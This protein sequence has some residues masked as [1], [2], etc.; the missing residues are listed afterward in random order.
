LRSG[1]LYFQ[2]NSTEKFQDP[3]SMVLGIIA[4][5]CHLSGGRKHNRRVQVQA[6]LGKKQECNSM[7]KITRGEGGK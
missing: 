2:A 1:G 4:C 6:H 3:I 7:S 5:A